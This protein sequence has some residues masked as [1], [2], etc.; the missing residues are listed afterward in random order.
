MNSSPISE[1]LFHSKRSAGRR[2]NDRV[3][4][5]LWY[6]NIFNIFSTWKNIFN[7]YIFSTRKIGLARLGAWVF[8]CIKE[9]YKP[10]QNLQEIWHK[11]W[12]KPSGNLT[13]ISRKSG[14]YCK[15]VTGEVSSGYSVR[16]PSKCC[17]HAQQQQHQQQR[18]HTC[19]YIGAA[20]LC[21]TRPSHIFLLKKSPKSP[22][23]L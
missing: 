20:H 15:T 4:V 1:R 12:S 11:F 21:T 9:H 13:K 2:V 16:L 8:M 22:K 23:C 19:S 14:G 5:D 7:I 18:I 17:F 3:K 6:L 10:E